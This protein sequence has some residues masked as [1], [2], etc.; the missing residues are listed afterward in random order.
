METSNKSYWRYDPEADCFWRPADNQEGYEILEDDMALRYSYSDRK[1]NQL[2][3][4]LEDYQRARAR[5]AK[6]KEQ[7]RAVAERSSQETQK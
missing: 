4:R 6:N 1:L 3:Y 5:G 7:R 2:S